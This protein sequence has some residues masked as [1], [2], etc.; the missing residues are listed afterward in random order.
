MRRI[1]ILLAAAAILAIALPA[2]AL[3]KECIYAGKGY[4]EGASRGGQTCYCDSSK[5]WWEDKV[6]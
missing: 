3:A 5:C 6:A 2:A 1:A 4:S